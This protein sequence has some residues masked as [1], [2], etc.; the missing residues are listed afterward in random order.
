MRAPHRKSLARQN[1][2]SGIL[3]PLAELKLRSPTARQNRTAAILELLR[4]AA[5]QNRRKQPQ[6]FYSVR[7]VAVHFDVSVATAERIFKKM[8]S[9]GLL[10]IIW[11]SKTLI[12]SAQLNRQLRIRG[13]VA[14][15][16]SLQ[17]FRMV[18]DYRAFFVE[19]REVLW[20]LGFATRLIF[21]EEHEAEEPAFAETLLKHKVDV[22]IWFLPSPKIKETAARL[23][24]RGI[25]LATVADSW[26]NS[27]EHCYRVD[28][29][30]AL[31]QAVAAWEEGGISSVAVVRDPHSKATGRIAMIEKSLRTI[32]MPYSFVS[33]GPKATQGC[34]RTLFPATNRAV[35][36]PSA[37]VPVRLA[38]QFPAQFAKLCK[39][40]R[41]LLM[42]GLIDLPA[43][44][45]L[46]CRVDV[47][48]VEWHAVTNRI[49][50]DLV[51]RPSKDKSVVFE[52]KWI[53]GKSIAPNHFA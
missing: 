47:I 6:P 33:V 22:V 43:G 9:E 36:F 42:E 14:L 51:K 20:K 38:N 23:I 26:A 16:A 40:C 17:P 8:R 52:A 12:E 44:E 10:R 5:T 18:R 24:D 13:V 4:N 34:W 53:P 37:T 30:T 35:L 39:E 3:T 45:A 25:Q 46:D 21:Y 11:G 49:G 32:T 27:G 41:V 31:K 29:Q 28:H 7:E 2:N 19:M 50:S 1:R 48:E 15:P